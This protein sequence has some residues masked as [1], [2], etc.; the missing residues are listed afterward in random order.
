M[1]TVGPRFG[2]WG[3]V[4]LR[5]VWVRGGQASL[6][7]DL[8]VILATLVIYFATREDLM[9]R[10]EYVKARAAERTFGSNVVP[11]KMGDHG[12]AQPQYILEVRKCNC[13]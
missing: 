13:N 11:L 3:S 9:A 12:P 6:A 8:S 7:A 10:R 2:P 5:F 1:L 4:V